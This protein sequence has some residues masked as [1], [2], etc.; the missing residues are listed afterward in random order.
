MAP[1][2]HQVFRLQFFKRQTLSGSLKLLT[3]QAVLCRKTRLS[4]LVQIK[5]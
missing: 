3:D 4:D 1:F 2:F 5:R